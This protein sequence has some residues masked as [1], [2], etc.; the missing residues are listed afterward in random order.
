M[1][2]SAKECLKKS[3]FNME[4]WSSLP[5]LENTFLDQNLT[6]MYIVWDSTV[7]VFCISKLNSLQNQCLYFK[8]ASHHHTAFGE[9]LFFPVLLQ[10]VS[11]IFTNKGTLILVIMPNKIS[12]PKF[13]ADVTNISGFLPLVIKRVYLRFLQT[14]NWHE[15]SVV[16]LS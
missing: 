10:W 1:W 6:Q 11:V 16:T 4:L 2:E 7:W 12:N 5:F 15:N 8:K 14:R 9:I 13:V 3:V